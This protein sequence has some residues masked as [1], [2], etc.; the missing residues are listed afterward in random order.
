MEAFKVTVEAVVGGIIFWRAASYGAIF[1]AGAG[2]CGAGVGVCAAEGGAI[3]VPGERGVLL[4]L[5]CPRGART[6]GK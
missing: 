2:V 3:P 1:A 6:S 5:P 4:P